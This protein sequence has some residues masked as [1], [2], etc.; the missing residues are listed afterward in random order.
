MAQATALNRLQGDSVQSRFWHPVTPSLLLAL[1]LPGLALLG[2]LG[3]R[4]FLFLLLAEDG[5]VTLGEVLGLGQADAD[6][7]H[8]T[9]SP[10]GPEIIALLSSPQSTHHGGAGGTFAASHCGNFPVLI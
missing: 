1:L 7:T 10:T 3:L 6:D 2:G 4:R 9:T 5:L 8:G